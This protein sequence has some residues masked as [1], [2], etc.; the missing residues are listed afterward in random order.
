VLVGTDRR[1]HHGNDE[2]NRGRTQPPT[3]DRFG[4]SRERF[5]T[6]LGWRSGEGLSHADLEAHLQLDAREL[7]RQPFKDRLE[8]RAERETRIDRVRDMDGVRRSS[9]EGGQERALETV[10]GRF[11]CAGSP[12][13][14]ASIT[15][16]IPPTAC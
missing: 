16:C 6:V 12:S 15:T 8:L 13:V 3:H 5:D 4:G 2:R 9:V 10:F 7:F 1:S 11:L 14:I